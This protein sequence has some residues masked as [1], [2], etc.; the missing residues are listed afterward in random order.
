[1]R[2]FWAALAAISAAAVQAAPGPVFT[3]DTTVRL[4]VAAFDSRGRFVS[5]LKT[6]DFVVAEDGVPQTL[7]AARLVRAADGPPTAASSSDAD[8]RAEAARAGV[9]LFAVYLD[10]YEV[11]R[12]NTDRVRAA[13]TEFLDDVV[14]PRDLVVVMRPLDSLLNIHLTHDRAAARAAIAAFSGRKGD[15]TPANDYERNF[16]G[17]DAAAIE[18]TRAQVTLSAL[19]ALAVHLGWASADARKTL[20]FVAEGLSR[21]MRRRGLN[22][23]TLDAVTRSANRFNVAIYPLDPAASG[24]GSA[25]SAQP[26]HTLA[27]ATD[28]ALAA[29]GDDVEPTL[30]RIA[31]DASAYYL[32]TYR[33]PKKI[34][35]HFHD[36]SVRIKRPGVTVRTREG[37][38]ATSPDDLLRAEWLAREAMPKKPVVPEPP[39]HLSPLIRPW[40]GVAR[41]DGGKTRVTFVWEPVRAVGVRNPRIAARVELTA[42]GSD[43][44]PLFQGAV[45]PTGTGLSAAGDVGML[46][47]VFDVPPGSVRLR[48]S[49]EDTSLQIIDSDVRDITVRD[50]AES[51]VIG[52]PEVLR[53]RN[54]LEYR[55][56]DADPDA[57]PVASREF[58][59]TERLLIRVPAYAPAGQVAVVSAR[60]LSR[61]GQ[62]IRDLPV[63][64][65][66][67]HGGLSQIDLR[68]AGLATAEYL[69]E[70]KAQSPAGEA[71][72]LIGF[73]VT[74]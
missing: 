12:D 51:V 54:A 49:I 3:P 73:R 53:A 30:K 28:G 17:S 39:R 23:P 52:T 10:E 19:N 25:E 48:M 64:G 32:L 22:L 7:E 72:D 9:R 57:A 16:I 31:S 62:P 68:L 42:L 5:T 33:S 40:F 65:P 55:A 2:A 37:Y 67:A 47:A 46:R 8:E 45:L 60:L 24:D 15:Y 36:V 41:G 20:I 56:L 70:I 44:A 29:S 50:L 38:W 18:Q 6:S 26:L 13:L 69:I 43:D 34:D 66:A 35:G 58:S 14:A 11:S 63:A 61:N 59:R 4:D 1:M 21:G 74:S 27:A 71:K